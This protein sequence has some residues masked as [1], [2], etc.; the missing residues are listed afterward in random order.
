MLLAFQC[1]N[2]MVEQTIK[3]TQRA[4]KIKK[5]K[6]QW[7]QQVQLY[8][9]YM[10]YY[11]IYSQSNFCRKTFWWLT[12]FCSYVIFSSDLDPS[13]GPPD[14]RQQCYPDEGWFTY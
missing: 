7:K 5:A 3:P 4:S 1:Q 14:T 9:V 13:S 11:Y 2:K 12:Y 6:T 10:L 8:Y